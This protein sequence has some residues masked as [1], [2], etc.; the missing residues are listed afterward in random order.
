MNKRQIKDLKKKRMMKLKYTVACYLG[1][2]HV[3]YLKKHKLLGYCGE[4]V[5]FQPNFI[6]N[7]PQL[8]KLHNNV[9]IAADVTFYEHDIINFM[10]K[11]FDGKIY[12]SHLTCIEIFDNCFIGGK[13]IIVG[14]VKIGPNAIVG[15]GSVVTKDVKPGTIVAGN[16][17]R[18][19]GKFEDLHE[20]RIK[21]DEIE[22]DDYFPDY[23]KIWEE[24]YNR[25][26]K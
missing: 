16:P 18:V 11:N 1:F 22:K 3:K 10:F 20:K 13:S 2:D 6:P 4:K 8:I 17:A 15:A 25:R 12:K 24:Y 14:N 26:D 9:K 21:Y 5:T 19:V 7:C 23:E